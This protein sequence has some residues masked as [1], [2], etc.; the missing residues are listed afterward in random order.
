MSW[1]LVVTAERIKIMMR[2]RVIASSVARII[3]VAMSFQ[4]L[5]SLAFSRVT[6]NTGR[7][8]KKSFLKQFSTAEPFSIDINREKLNPLGPPDFLQSLSVGES[9][10]SMGRNITRLSNEPH[11]FL[12]KNLISIEDRKILIQE[13]IN[14]GMKVAG[15]R[16]SGE[17][18]VR[19]NSYLA[20]IDPY[21]ISDGEE[22]DWRDAPSIARETIV[23][24]RQCFAHD[25]MNDVMNSVEKMDVCFAEDL[26]I[27]KYD[28]N[29]RFDYHHDG[30]SRYLSVLIYLNGVGGTYFP[31]GDMDLD[32]K[33]FTNDDEVSV[34]SIKRQFER[35]GILIVGDEGSDAY[36]QSAFVKPKAVIQIEAG[37]AIAF[38]NYMPGGEKDLRQLHCAL[39]AQREKWIATA[40][41]RSDAL[42]GPFS[43]LKKTKLLESW[44]VYNSA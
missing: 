29:G 42:T 15:T 33:D 4:P 39:P 5:R 2:M 26:Q 14:Q 22:I 34:L 19:K 3:H 41:F 40:W 6:S 18:T 24:S 37:D 32:G 28:V 31:F 21:S 27:A 12:A 7:I 1:C 23:R 30:Y 9:F 10:S 13:A 20:W 38:Y 44:R 36:L 17:N 11:I 16:Q 25:V 43:L 35:C 8:H